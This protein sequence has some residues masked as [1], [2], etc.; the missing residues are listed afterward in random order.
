[1]TNLPDFSD[2]RTPTRIGRTNDDTKREERRKA[3]LAVAHRYATDAE[4][5]RELLAMLGLNATDGR[6][7]PSRGDA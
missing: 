5:C 6:R 2:F 4:D 3:T 1:M 7:Q